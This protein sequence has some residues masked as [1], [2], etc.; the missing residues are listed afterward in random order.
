MYSSWPDDDGEGSISTFVFTRYTY[1][2]AL[3]TSAVVLAVATLLSAASLAFGALL[4]RSVGR[5]PYGQP[6]SAPQGGVVEAEGLPPSPNTVESGSAADN[7]PL[8]LANGKR[9]AAVVFVRFPATLIQT[10]LFLANGAAVAAGVVIGGQ[11]G[12]YRDGGAGPTAA[13][14]ICAVLIIGAALLSCAAVRRI[15]PKRCFLEQPAP[16]PPTAPYEAS[17]E[18]SDSKSSSIPSSPSLWLCAV[19]V[20]PPE[21]ASALGPI[22]GDLSLLSPFAPLLAFAAPLLL[23]V[24]SVAV[25][26]AEQCAA[27]PFAIGITYAGYAVLV[28]VVRPFL[29]VAQWRSH[30]L[31]PLPDC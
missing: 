13:A 3:A 15:A 14:A 1:A 27:L 17:K 12:G 5:S 18:K 8:H 31:P 23:L 26:A 29:G 4:G 25:S 16:S 9:V 21:V 10:F 6:R 30:V 28:A 7:A 11:G 19:A 22:L 24:V 2:A 20:H